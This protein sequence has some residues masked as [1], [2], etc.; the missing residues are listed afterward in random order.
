MQESFKVQFLFA[1]VALVACVSSCFGQ[2][3]ED[4]YEM[5]RYANALEK[6]KRWQE[7]LKHPPK[8]PDEQLAATMSSDGFEYPAFSL[9]FGVGFFEGLAKIRSHG[10]VGYINR[11]GKTQIPAKFDE[12]GRF[13]EGLARVRRGGKWGFTDRKGNLR[14]AP[15]F[16]WVASFFEGRALV[17]VGDKW[18]YIDKTG[19]IVISPRFDQASSFSEGLAAV[20]IYQLKYKTGYI[21]TSGNWVLQPTY[22]GGSDFREG[23][24]IVGQDIVTNSG[25]YNESHAISKTGQRLFDLDSAYLS[26]Y[27]E[28]RLVVEGA[29]R[30]FGYLNL[31]G[32]LV[33]PHRFDH[34]NEFS[35]GLASVLLGDKWIY[36]DKQGRVRLRPQGDCTGSF[37]SGL[38]PCEVTRKYGFIDRTGK[39]VIKPRFDWVD[40]F[41]GQ[42]AAVF[43]GE[44]VGYINRKGEHVW[45]PTE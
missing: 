14:I 18:G 22:D 25:G 38:A 42:L 3:R 12:G 9:R 8:T 33:I 10:K 20:R 19:K 41:R 6:E 26:S 40:G 30:E 43:V 13:S 45:K 28:G 35:E 5:R 39:F 11:F 21:D 37:E 16:E 23:V 27:S 1:V 31:K 34:A 4:S 29:G 7:H 44:K 17:K 15:R 32:D 24:A 2:L 36:I